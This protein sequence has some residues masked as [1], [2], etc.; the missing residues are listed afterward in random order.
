MRA[1]GEGPAWRGERGRAAAAE[2]WGRRPAGSCWL[3]LDL[4]SGS[5]QIW[6]CLSRALV[7]R[8]THTPH[9]K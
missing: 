4:E 8:H 2:G 5:P 6:F 9:R 3:R 7:C 1:T